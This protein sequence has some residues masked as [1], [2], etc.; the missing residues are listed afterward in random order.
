[1]KICCL[2]GE[3]GSGKSTLSAAL[4]Q[5]SP[6]AKR[7]VTYTTR[8][9]RVGEV[10]GVDYYFVTDDELKAMDNVVVKEDFPPMGSFAVVDDGQ[11]DKRSRTAVYLVDGSLTRAQALVKHYGEKHVVV[12][13]VYL[14]DETR[15]L[16][17]CG[18]AMAGDHNYVEV[19]RRFLADKKDY[20][21]AQFVA[22]GL[23]D[24]RLV[25]IS[26]ETTTKE[27][28]D[29]LGLKT[30]ALQKELPLSTDETVAMMTGRRSR[31]NGHERQQRSNR[32]CDG[33]QGTRS[34]G[35]R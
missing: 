1:M 4:T 34:R 33:H 13:H 2:V 8:P 6:N 16:R 30:V 35:R 26:L 10:H 17:M 23:R 12:V 29:I 11:V 3:S 28:A 19:C 25:N 14:D 15:L 9:P 5:M 20:A 31:G 18:R 21:P 32:S 7:L 27:L 22:H 24:E